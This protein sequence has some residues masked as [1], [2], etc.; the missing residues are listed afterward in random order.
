MD[1]AMPPDAL[2]P[3]LPVPE[4]PVPDASVSARDPAAPAQ[5][6]GQG[7]GQG[8]GQGAAGLPPLGPRSS[9]ADLA[10]A[11]LRQA[12]ITLAL[13]P[14]TALSRPGIA[15]HLQVSQTPVRE[16]LLR[17]Q[18][19]KLV[20]VVPHSATRVACIDLDDARQGHFLRLAVEVEMVRQQARQA[21]AGGGPEGLARALP[22]HLARQRA[23][24][25]VGDEPGFAAAD[26]AFHA[27]FYAAAGMSGLW[28][29]IHTHSGHLDRL[30]RLH[31]PS[32]GKAE[33]ILRAHEALAGAVL[34]GRPEE[35][36]ALL[37]AH[38]SDTFTRVEEIR[39]AHPVFFSL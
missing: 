31:L 1:P 12:I 10:Y 15:A 14:G 6:D 9:A 33:A 18:E 27:A 21:A 3:Q 2:P 11:Y 4:S 32:P 35:A 36:E 29:M 24:L 8:T 25:A 38:L 20:E 13:P 37:R 22:A 26:D 16:A 28:R 23:L 39:R 30:R 19:E 34:G 7:A 17:L 5:G